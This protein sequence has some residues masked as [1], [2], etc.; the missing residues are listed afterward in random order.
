MGEKE[1]TQQTQPKKGDPVTI[2]VPTRDEIEDA[3]SKVS[4]PLPAKPK[5]KHAKRKRD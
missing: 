5:R 3:I 2:P 1:P 4:Q